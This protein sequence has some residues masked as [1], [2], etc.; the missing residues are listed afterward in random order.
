MC[1]YFYLLINLCSNKEVTI[2]MTPECAVLNS[3]K[4]I[5]R[6]G[7]WSAGWARENMKTALKTR[8]SRQTTLVVLRA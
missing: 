5:L 2:S 7:R 3:S 8:L 1:V 4:M 6:R